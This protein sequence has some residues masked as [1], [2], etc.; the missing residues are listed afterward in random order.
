MYTLY[1]A[2]YISIKLEEKNKITIS[3]GVGL[4]GHKRGKRGL[5]FYYFNVWVLSRSAVSDSLWSHGLARQANFLNLGKNTGLGSHS[6]L[7][8]IFP[9]KGSNTGL[10]HC[11]RILY[12]LS[13]QRSP[14]F[15]LY[16]IILILQDHLLVFSIVLYSKPI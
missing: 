2:Y 7:K 12:H 15:S 1:R 3:H 5:L 14:I 16:I 6:L 10:L 4:I 11:R 13:H 9:T 8:G